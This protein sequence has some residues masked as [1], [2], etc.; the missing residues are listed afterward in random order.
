MLGKGR[1]NGIQIVLHDN[2]EV[3][4]Y[5]SISAY[6]QAI[7]AMQQEVQHVVMGAIQEVSMVQL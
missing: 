1:P 6:I 2:C 5:S 7:M 3:C 4:Q